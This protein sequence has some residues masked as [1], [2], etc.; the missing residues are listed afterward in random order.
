MEGT[1]KD[2]RNKSAWVLAFLSFA[3]VAAVAARDGN[4]QGAPNTEGEVLRKFQARIDAYMALHNRLE[5]E[6]P[7]LKAA[8]D[9]EQIRESQKALAAKIRA[10][11]RNPSQGAIF[12]PETRTVFRRILRRELQ[13]PR[14]AELERA[15]KDDASPRIPLRVHAEYPEGWPLASVPPS[16]LAA[17]PKLPADLA[18]RFVAYDMIL[19]DVHAN[20]IIDFIQDA[21]R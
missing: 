8:A 5:K 10:A 20:L 7:P 14:A 18:Y 17:L 1:V 21:I 19:L 4:P 11:R 15:M 12:T 6:S 13:G 16:L 3:L 2:H 9:P